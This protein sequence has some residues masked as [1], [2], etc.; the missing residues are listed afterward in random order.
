[1]EIQPIGIIRSPFRTK[2]EAPIQGAFQPDAE[3]T[4]ELLE[5]VS[6]LKHIETFSHLF[7]MY[8]FGRV[9]EKVFKREW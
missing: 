6:G 9:G 3:G 7:L 8:R 2:E 4:V 5:F 1:M